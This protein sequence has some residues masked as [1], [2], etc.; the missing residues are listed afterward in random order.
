MSVSVPIL[1][2]RN[3]HKKYRKDLPYAVKD[4]TFSIKRGVFFALVG[5]NGAGKTTTLHMIVGGILP[6]SG[7]ILIDGVPSSQLTSEH[8]A[9]MGFVP[10][11]PSYYPKA[12]VGSDLLGF[13]GQLIGLSKSESLRFATEFLKDLDG[14]SLLDKTIGALS[15]GER[16]KIAFALAFLGDPALLILDEPVSHLDPFSREIIYDRMKEFVSNGGTILFSSHS[17]IE[18]ERLA[19]RIGILHQGTLVEEANLKELL[20]KYK[21]RVI[22]MTVS[23]STRFEEILVSSNIEFARTE[24]LFRIPYFNLKEDA[25]KLMKIICQHDITIYS[26]TPSTISLEELILSRKLV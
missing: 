19:Q 1:E 24:S 12:I 11:E 2:L 7:E 5:P 3:V 15:T 14:V 25:K 8:R 21:S 20:E 10:A 23:D 4:L 18:V 26:M 9:K 6:T 13:K 17:L 22:E 16:Q